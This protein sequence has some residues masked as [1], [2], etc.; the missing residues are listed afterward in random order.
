MTTA[1]EAP[2]TLDQF[3][4]DEETKHPG[5]SGQFSSLI[6]SIALA[7]KIIA[8]AVSRAGL[9]SLT[10]LAGK[11]NVQGEEV[12]KLDEYA[13]SVFDLVLGRTGHF[14]SFVSEEREEVFKATSGSKDS[15]Y[16]V[17]YDPL[18][19]SSN[20][21]TNIA[22]GSIWGIYKRIARG[23][24]TDTHDFLQQTR[25]QVAAGYVVYGSSC[26]F[27]YTT[28]T[29]VH[30]FTLDYEIGEFVLTHPNMQMPQSGKSYSCNQGN[31][32]NWDEDVKKYIDYVSAEG[33]GRPFSHR[34]VGSLVADFHRIMLK[35]GIFLYPS[36]K[37]NKN[38]KLRLL[39]E[40]APLA[41]IAEQAGGKAT[42]GAKNILDVIPTTVHER[43]PLIIG[44]AHEVER[45]QTFKLSA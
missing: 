25:K 40:C 16:V 34:Y 45:L 3:I 8:R 33:E 21:D 14:S 18:D 7:A 6:G 31:Y 42:N 35:G 4:L 23:S 36:D 10:G 44:S 17:A 37:K 29:G 30:G 11:T 32:V 28:G 22:I 5:A 19:G 15:G 20:I 9:T 1:F 43:S 12:Q 41:L 27:V 26:M 2:K 39:Y 38:G 24:D 13:D